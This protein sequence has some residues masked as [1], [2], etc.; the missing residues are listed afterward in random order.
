MRA[1]AL[2]S[3]L[4]LCDVKKADVQVATLTAAGGIHKITRI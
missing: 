2:L 3:Y 1:R 4:Q